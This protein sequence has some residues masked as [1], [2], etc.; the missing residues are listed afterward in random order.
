[1][2]PSR[3]ARPARPRRRRRRKVSGD[4]VR[5][6]VGLGNPGARYQNTP[7][8]LGFQVVTHLAE[9]GGVRL[10]RREAHARTA[11]AVLEATEVVLA[12]PE[13]FMNASGLAVG[14]LVEH[15]GLKPGEVIVVVDD[16]ALPW[17]MLRIRERGSAGGHN[18]LE[19]VIAALGSEAFVRLR[20]GIRPEGPVDDLA[21]Y[22]LRPLAA[23]LRA[24]ARS[25]VAEA[26]QA[27][28]A[29]LVEGVRHAMTRYN[30]RV[31]AEESS[32]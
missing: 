5:L 13:T 4:G 19:S 9:E 10:A 17:G 23:S 28:R 22:V 26:S 32:R 14:A 7:H 27:V 3:H 29:I 6:I 30:R 24:T 12:Q 8:N 25:A 16:V 18:G 11:R 1:M 15:Y 2:P 21:D 31:P 20:V